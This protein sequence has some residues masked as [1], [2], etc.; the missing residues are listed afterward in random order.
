MDRPTTL[1]DQEDSFWRDVDRLLH[2]KAS[3]RNRNR[4]VDSLLRIREWNGKGFVDRTDGRKDG[5]SERQCLEAIANERGVKARIAAGKG[6]TGKVTWI[7]I[8]LNDMKLCEVRAQFGHPWRFS[9]ILK[10]L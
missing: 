8:P 6:W 7:H 4:P 3:R 2:R 10:Q 5:K 9:H 1:L